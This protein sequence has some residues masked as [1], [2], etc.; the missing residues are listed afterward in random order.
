MTVKRSVSE[1][2]GGGAVM[3]DMETEVQ[4][5]DSQALVSRLSTAGPVVVGGH[6]RAGHWA[7]GF[8]VGSPVHAQRAPPGVGAPAAPMAPAGPE[9]AGLEAVGRPRS[10][11]QAAEGLPGAPRLSAPGTSA[12]ASSLGFPT[13][14]DRRSS[15]GG[16]TCQGP[17]QLSR[18]SF[19]QPRGVFS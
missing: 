4:G 6:V 10:R 8:L 9:R 19:F 14:Q 17:V 1:G 5:C 15:R 12:Q 11:A 7:G 16:R 13:G 2:R 18:A 3:E